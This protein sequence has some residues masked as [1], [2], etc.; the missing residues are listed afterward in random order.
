MSDDEFRDY[1][2]MDRMALERARRNHMRSE[3][4]RDALRDNMKLSLKETLKSKRKDF[5]RDTSNAIKRG[6]AGALTP[7]QLAMIRAAQQ[8]IEQ[9]T[10]IEEIITGYDPLPWEND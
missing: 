7:D 10:G 9:V 2:G 8:G 4:R 1:S 6:E 5:I 3:A